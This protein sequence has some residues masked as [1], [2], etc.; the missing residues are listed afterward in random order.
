MKVVRLVTIHGYTVLEINAV[1]LLPGKY[2]H[3]CL[4]HKFSI[5]CVSVAARYQRWCVGGWYTVQ[6][7]GRLYCRPG[8]LHNHTGVCK[9]RCEQSCTVADHYSH[10]VDGSAWL[11]HRLTAWCY[12]PVLWYQHCSSYCSSSSDN[13]NEKAT[14][15]RL[16]W[17]PSRQRIDSSTACASCAAP[18]AVE[19][20][21]SV[22]S[23]LC[24]Y[25]HVAV[26]VYFTMG[27]HM[28]PELSLSI[29]NLDPI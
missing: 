20:S 5:C 11:T 7:S 29:R 17:H 6:C 3:L 19:S 13:Y 10:H 2:K 26:S 8:I 27:R 23:M 21:Q 28:T 9:R 14:R 24:T 18:I 4:W 1:M 16:H 25:C 12:A 15:Y 22:S